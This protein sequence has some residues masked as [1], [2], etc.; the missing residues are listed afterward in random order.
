MHVPKEGAPMA[1]MHFKQFL[2]QAS[3]PAL[4]SSCPLI[5]QVFPALRISRRLR[6]GLE[7]PQQVPFR[8][9]MYRCGARYRDLRCRMTGSGEAGHPGNFLR[10]A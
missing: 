3:A 1:A 2:H 9:T 10:T 6:H 8:A 5:P 4:S 7:P